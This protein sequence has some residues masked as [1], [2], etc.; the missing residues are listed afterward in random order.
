VGNYTLINKLLCECNREIA[1]DPI[2]KLA[3][4]RD[5][6]T[7]ICERCYRFKWSWKLSA[8]N[9]DNFSRVNEKVDTAI[10][11]KKGVA[12]KSWPIQP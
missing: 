11:T 3:I 6:S 4:Y 5:G 2:T 1:H 10:N 12:W 7:P 8:D 9:A